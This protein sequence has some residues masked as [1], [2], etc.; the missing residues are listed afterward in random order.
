MEPAGIVDRRVLV[1]A[2]GLEQEDVGAAVDEPASD[3]AT[4]RAG[5]DDDGVRAANAHV[6][7]TQTLLTS[8]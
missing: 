6:N 5:A 2:A 4:G 1:A 7:E 3:D 8:V